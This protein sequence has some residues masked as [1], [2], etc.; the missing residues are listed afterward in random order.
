MEEKVVVK[1]NLV[2]NVKVVQKKGQ[3][4]GQEEG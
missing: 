1:R 2:E 4:K 3:E